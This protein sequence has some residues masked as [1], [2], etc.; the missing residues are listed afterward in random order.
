MSTIDNLR[1]SD[2]LSTTRRWKFQ[3]LDIAF[4]LFGATITLLIWAIS[5]D[6]A[7]RLTLEDGF[8]ENV[9]S[10]FYLLAILLGTFVLIRQNPKHKR[11]CQSHQNT[12][13]N[14]G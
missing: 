14:F 11:R 8:I 10:V 5:P 6:V 4:L 7:E 3:K 1:T 12:S 9:T 2:N 13:I